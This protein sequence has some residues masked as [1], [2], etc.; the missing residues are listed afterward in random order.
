[1]KLWSI[2]GQLIKTL[3][4]HSAEVTSVCFSPDGKSIV[5]ASED[6]TI[7]F[8]SGDGTL[9]RTFN[10]HQGPVR[11]VCFSPN[12]K[13]LVS[14]GEDHKIIMWNLDLENLLMRGC[15]WLQEYL[16]TNTN[17][18]EEDKHTCL[19]GCGWLYKHLKSTPPS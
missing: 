9:L 17:V 1:V 14:S 5:S 12:G 18:S 19:G 10:G 15:Q 7:Q 8:W 4:G 16:R 11:S 2:E 3:N 6:S 13:I